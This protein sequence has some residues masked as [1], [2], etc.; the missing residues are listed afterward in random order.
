MYAEASFPIEQTLEDFKK[1]KYLSQAF[2]NKLHSSMNYLINLDYTSLIQQIKN[3]LTKNKYHVTSDLIYIRNKNIKPEEYI[4]VVRLFNL[5]YKG[6][7]IIVINDNITYLPSIYKTLEIGYLNMQIE[8]IIKSI[9][10]KMFIDLIQK[11]EMNK[12]EK[13]KLLITTTIVNKLN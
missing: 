9:K 2:L 8:K 11:R 10:T 3:K 12:I 4:Y 13:A 1:G 5:T 6:N 7:K